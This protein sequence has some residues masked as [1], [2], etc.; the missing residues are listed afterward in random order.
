MPCQANLLT[1][2]AAPRL[3]LPAILVWEDGWHLPQTAAL[4]GWLLVMISSGG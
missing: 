1:R 4:T 3:P 2:T